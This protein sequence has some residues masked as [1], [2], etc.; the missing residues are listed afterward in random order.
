VLAIVFLLGWLAAIFGYIFDDWWR[1]RIIEDFWPI[2]NSTLSPNLVA[3]VIQY[4][5]II[6]T[7]VLAYPPARD[8]FKREFAKASAER[9]AHHDEATAHR[10]ELLRH[11]QHIIKHHPDIPPLEP[12]MNADT[13]TE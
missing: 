4:A 10:D 8:F 9:A 2:D 3:T 5:I 12:K 6:V 13:S 1:H 7:V 11:V